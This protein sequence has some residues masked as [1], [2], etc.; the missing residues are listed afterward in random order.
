MVEGRRPGVRAGLEAVGIAGA[1]E[2]DG[3]GTEL[4]SSDRKGKIA[5]LLGRAE[6]EC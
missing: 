2:A 4:D 6:W 5:E 3:R 1:R